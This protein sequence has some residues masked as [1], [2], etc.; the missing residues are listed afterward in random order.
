M[1]T[2]LDNHLSEIEASFLLRQ[3]FLDRSTAL[4]QPFNRYL[5]S[6]IPPGGEGQ[7]RSFNNAQFFASLET[8]GAALPFRSS[9]KRKAF[10]ERFLR[11]PV[12]GAW[13]AEAEARVVGYGLSKK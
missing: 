11:T 7:L 5:A 10:Y 3:H 1:F 13:L 6:L 4:L 9:S 8:H 12:F 2:R